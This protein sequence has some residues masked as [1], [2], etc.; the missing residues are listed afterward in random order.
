MS[1]RSL[2]AAA[3]VSSSASTMMWPLLRCNPSANLSNVDTSALR[4]QGL[5]TP[6]RLSSSFTRPV[7]AI[8]GPPCSPL[9]L[10]YSPE[11]ARQAPRVVPVGPTRHAEVGE[12]QPSAELVGCHAKFRDRVPDRGAV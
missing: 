9:P 3:P 11:G 12:H 8:S 10:E 6:T 2:R 5:S 1:L 4:Q 7:S